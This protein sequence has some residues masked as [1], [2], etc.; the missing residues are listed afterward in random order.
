VA[1]ITTFAGGTDW[2]QVTIGYNHTAAIKTDGTLW[3]WGDG[4]N[5]E[6]GA[7]VTANLLAI[8]CTPVTTFAGGT[9]WKQVSCGNFHT[10]AIKTDGPL[11][12][13]GFNNYGQLGNGVV[14][15]RVTPLTTFAG[16][17]NWKQVSSCYNSTLAV[18]S[19]ITPDIPLS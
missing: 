16:G 4:S 15:N 11:W 13:W 3:V 18:L 12:T 19:G 6:L 1:L 8:R 9:N 2:K 7:N 17:T 10:S 5:G 14:G